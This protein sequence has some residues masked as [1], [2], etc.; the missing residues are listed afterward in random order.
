MSDREGEPDEIEPA[1]VR[2]SRGCAIALIAGFSVAFLATSL[3]LLVLF[4]TW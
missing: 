1:Q 4:L 2:L 3:V